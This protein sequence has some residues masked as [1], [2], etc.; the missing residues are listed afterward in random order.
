MRDVWERLPQLLAAATSVYGIVLKIDTTKKI[1][2]KLQG[3]AAGTASW[4]TNVRNERGE[5]VISILTESEDS[6]ALRR[7]ACGQMDRCEVAH[8]DPPR[9]LYTDRDCCSTS[10]PSKYQVSK[11]AQIGEQISTVYSNFVGSI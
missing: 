5:V 8:Q 3:A 7:I 4:A 9:L 10:G 11:Q 2:K 1:C 6:D